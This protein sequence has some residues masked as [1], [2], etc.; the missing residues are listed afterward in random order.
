MSQLLADRDV[1]ECDKRDLA[2]HADIRIAG[3]IAKD[4]ATFPLLGAARSDKKVIG[5]LNFRRAQEGCNL[6]KDS[7]REDVSALYAH[8]LAGLKFANRKKA[9]AVNRAD[10]DRRFR[11][12]IGE[13]SWWHSILA[14]YLGC[15]RR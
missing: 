14:D 13:R 11:R 3:M 15:E 9:T 7:S 12:E 1:P 4:H 6:V 5:D 10:L 2:L 8:D